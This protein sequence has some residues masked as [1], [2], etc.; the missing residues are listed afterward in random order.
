MVIS[1]ESLRQDAA[2]AFRQFRRRPRFW[3]V[4]V[5]TLVVGMAASTCIYAVVDG[6]LLA[7]LPYPDAE[8]LVRVN[9]RNLRGE[10]LYL[11]ERATTLDVAAYYP[12]QPEVTVNTDGVPSR[13]AAAGVTADLFDVLGVHPVLGRGFAAEETRA[14]G[15]GIL[16][17]TYW[18]T[19]GVVILSAG[20]W[21]THFAGDASAIG[22]TLSIEGVPHTVVGVMPASFNFPSAAT[23]LWFPH[24]IDP[25][26]LWNGNVAVTIG[27]LRDGRTLAEAREEVQTLIPAFLELIPFARF[28]RNYGADADVR[29]LADDIVGGARPL[30]LLMLASIGVVLLVVCTNVANFLLA[31]GAARERELATRAALGAERSRLVRQLL[32]ENVAIAVVAGLLG[33]LASIGSLSLIV[34]LLPPD[35]PRVEEISIDARVLAFAFTVSLATGLGFGL[36]PALRATRGGTS[37]A[38]RHL[39]GA[40]TDPVE[41]RLTRWLAASELALSVALVVAAVLLLR[42]LWNLGSVDPGFQ[43]HRLVAGRVAPPGFEDSAPALQNQFSASL[44]ERLEAAPGVQ[45]A[46]LATAI[47]LDAGLYGASF[48]TETP[49]ATDAGNFTR[50]YLGVTAGYFATMGTPLLA[51]RVFDSRDRADS[52]RVSIVSQAL[53]RANWETRIRSASGFGFRTTGSP[54]STVSR[55]HGSPSSAWSTTSGLQDRPASASR[56]CICRSSSSGA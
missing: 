49:G 18:R 34:S 46:A 15:P 11:R 6:V 40:V 22:S 47:P 21:Q 28:L 10:Y 14:D 5:T 24:N 48:E 8:R 53:A 52:A 50:A 29:G 20:F 32:V 16:G 38:N 26:A 27:R 13:V 30:L 33:T 55:G 23:E 9:T 45:A 17:G 2:F 41:G 4:I 12:T 44:L 42:S 3:A 36:L 19:Y 35:L 54:P 7:P 39:A 25:A 1:L 43:A 37:L 31:H 56:C 51:G